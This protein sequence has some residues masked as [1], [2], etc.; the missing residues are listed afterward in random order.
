MAMSSNLSILGYQ[1]DDNFDEVFKN[2]LFPIEL[3]TKKNNYENHQY[4]LIKELDSYLSHLKSSSDDDSLVFVEAA[5][6]IQNVMVIY[7]KKVDQ[8][9]NDMTK[10]I[11][12]FQSYRTITNG[13]EN[14]IEN[15]AEGNKKKKIE[16]EVKCFSSFEPI[17]IKLYNSLKIFDCKKINLSTLPTLQKTV[18]NTN[19]KVTNKYNSALPHIM[20]GNGENIGKKYDYKM[21]F[22]LNCS[23]AINQ[24]LDCPANVDHRVKNVNILPMDLMDVDIDDGKDILQDSLDPVVFSQ[25]IHNTMDEV[26][27]A[28]AMAPMPADNIMDVDQIPEVIHFDE[29]WNCVNANNNIYSD[30]PFVK[31]KCIKKK[32]RN[33]T[34]WIPK[35]TFEGIGIKKLELQLS[36]SVDLGSKTDPAFITYIRIAKKTQKA[37]IFKIRMQKMKTDKQTNDEELEELNTSNNEIYVDNDYDDLLGIGDAEPQSER[38]FRDN[39]ETYRKLEEDMRQHEQNRMEIINEELAMRKRVD[40]WHDKL[41]PIL[42]EEEKKT[43]FDVHAYGTDILNSF[44]HVGEEKLFK[45]LVKD[46]NSSDVSRYF[47]SVLMMANTYNLKLSNCDSKFCLKLLKKER[48]HEELQMNIGNQIVSNQD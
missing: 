9:V 17:E 10:L 40:A 32:E 14:A 41:R 23:L 34:F 1:N 20:V 35:Y 37:N 39:Y 8:I 28:N 12:K 2:L 42:K 21:N 13:T 38:H 11:W 29:A 15:E 30:K 36:I 33:N 16:K 7:Q 5:L 48:H 45:D 26:F 18:L 46:K 3:I 6:M 43:E 19:I 47:L 25:T 24:D 44:S 31:K 27:A 22:P 4:D